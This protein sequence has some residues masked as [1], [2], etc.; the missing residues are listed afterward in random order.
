MIE[1][2]DF[3]CPACGVYAPLVEKLISEASTTLRFVFRH[4]PLD[5]INAYGVVQH[6]NA[7]IASYAAE[8]A[9][10]QGKFWEMY[11]LIYANQNEWVSLPDAHTV[12]DGYAQQIGLDMTKFKADLDSDAVKTAVL[13]DQ[14][15]GKKIGI[16]GT[17]TFFVNGKAITNPQS[18]DAFKA[19]I[20]A[21]A[22]GSSK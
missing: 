4:F 7:D 11:K 8:A 18:Y 5:Q 13:A 6:P 1:Y 20:E 17:P 21:A 15:E 22:S 3:Q 10:M 16:S 19:L 9:S 2:G 14:T 12:L